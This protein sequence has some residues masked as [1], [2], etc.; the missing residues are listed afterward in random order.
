MEYDMGDGVIL[1]PS[2]VKLTPTIELL[3]Q[4]LPPV[5]NWFDAQEYSTDEPWFKL[6]VW[7]EIE[8]VN[9][10]PGRLCREELCHVRGFISAVYLLAGADPRTI[11]E[12]TRRD[13]DEAFRTAQA[14]RSLLMVSLLRR[15]ASPSCLAFPA[16]E[17]RGWEMGVFGR[18][19]REDLAMMNAAKLAH[20]AVESMLSSCRQKLQVNHSRAA[21]GVWSLSPRSIPA[22][23]NILMFPL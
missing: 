18:S 2:M 8:R 20:E 7:A 3:K 14:E 5:T 1:A 22:A 9:A 15:G 10:N 4:C 16:Y 19:R 11:R 6:G 21:L 23:S 12:V 17:P 13:R